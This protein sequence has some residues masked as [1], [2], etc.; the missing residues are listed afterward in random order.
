ML[1]TDNTHSP[2]PRLYLTTKL[3]NP[4]YPPEVCV[5]VSLLNFF[6]TPEG[7]EEQ[8]LN[9]VVMHERCE[10]CCTSPLASLVFWLL[11]TLLLHQCIYLG[12]SLLWRRANQ[13]QALCAVAEL[14][15]PA[16]LP[17]RTCI[18]L[19]RPDLASQKSS[20]VVGNAQMRSELAGVEE[21]ILQLLSSSS[22]NILD[23][24]LLIDTLAQAKVC[25]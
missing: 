6:V 1:S 8:L 7:L 3:R 20:L 13:E 14:R 15:P 4:H 19:H 21:R 23:D 5:K 24:E 16:T 17:S 2:F 25:A 12:K 9:T 22:G 11:L 18:A 10:W